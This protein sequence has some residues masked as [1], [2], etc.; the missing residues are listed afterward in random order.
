MSRNLFALVSIFFIAFLFSC[1]KH[2]KKSNSVIGKWKILSAHIVKDYVSFADSVPKYTRFIKDSIVS[3]SVIVEFKKDSTLSY[4]DAT[5]N[6]KSPIQ[7]FVFV[8]ENAILQF[9][10]RDTD[11]F[12]ID[13]DTLL[14]W[15]VRKYPSR[16]TSD[17]IM[18]KMLRIKN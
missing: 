2:Q 13:G 14:L 1:V 4:F 18:A 5:L 10:V 8:G 11:H 17:S 15:K 6:K 16:F 7:K 12:L 3:D 9:H